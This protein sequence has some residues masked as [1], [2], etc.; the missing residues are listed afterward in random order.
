MTKIITIL[1]IS[2]LSVSIVSAA[3]SLPVPPIPADETAGI[4]TG[5]SG[6]LQ[7]GTNNVVIREVTGHG[8]NR[9]EAVKSA[10]YHAVQQVRG[11][12]VGSGAYES[13]YNGA[14]TDNKP[15]QPRQE[16][17]NIIAIDISSQG[18]VYATEIGSLIKGYNII[19]EEQIDKDTY[20]VRMSVS[21]F[22]DTTRGQSNRIKLTRKPVNYIFLE[23]SIPADTLCTL[24]YQQ[25][26]AGLTATNKFSVLDRKNLSSFAEEKKILLSFDAPVSEQAKLLETLD[27]DYLLTGTITAAGIEKTSTYLQ[28]AN[29]TITQYK[30]S[31]VFNY[32][33]V[34]SATK[35]IILASTEKKYLDDEQVRNLADEQDPARWNSTRIRDAFLALAVN[36]IL[37]TVIDHVYP[38]KIIDVQQD[39]Q[40]VLN[41]GSEKITPGV[42]FDIFAQGNELFDPETKESL[43]KAENYVASIEIIKVAES[44][45]YAKLVSGNMSQ[46][47]KGLTCRIKTT[48]EKPADAAGSK[49]NVIRTESGGVKLPFDR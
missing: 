10:L 22:S 36:D 43:G 27:A 17:I 4:P 39:G 33:L 44:M 31:F 21:V 14:V 25:L 42:V 2:I 3:R 20:Y 49:S 28:A 40:I 41:Q 18:T 23:Q 12:G 45:S 1:A 8:H 15:P 13:I 24:L 11:V 48:T 6:L 35:E 30:G 32:R 5:T 19:S 38:I 9:D 7:T 37:K 26:A 29:Y 16:G 47:S 46:I 34:D